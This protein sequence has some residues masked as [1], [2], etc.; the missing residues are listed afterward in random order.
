[1]AESNP[2]P[3]IRIDPVAPEAYRLWEL[4]LELA[5]ALGV[6]RQWSP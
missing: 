6:E 1:M 3:T 2:Y 5:G 4:T